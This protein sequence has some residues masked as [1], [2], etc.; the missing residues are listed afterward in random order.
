MLY[1]ALA[2]LLVAII[3]AVFGFGGL[4]SATAG[5]A[6]ILFFVFIALSVALLLFRA[7][8]D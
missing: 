7:L 2:F 1:Y 5:I 6:Q 8:R 3:S 4:A